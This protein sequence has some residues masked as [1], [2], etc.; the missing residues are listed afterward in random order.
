LNRMLAR[1]FFISFSENM[2]SCV[3]TYRGPF[4]G[5]ISFS[6]NMLSCVKTYRGP[7]RGVIP[8]MVILC[9][10]CQAEKVLLEKDS[11]YN[12]IRV[13]EEGRFISLYC[14]N[15]HQSMVDTVHPDRL[16]FNYTKSM[17]SVFTFKNEIP[18][19]ILLIGEGGGSIPKA[20]QKD[21]PGVRLDIVELDQEVH[22]AAMK[23]FRFK[24]AKNTTINIIDGRMFVKKTKKKYDIVM[25]DAFRGGYIP[26][27]M[28]TSE[29]LGQVKNVLKPGGIVVSNTFDNSRIRDRE[30]ATYYSV[31]KNVY[32]LIASGSGNRII[33]ADNNPRVKKEDL[34]N[35]A[36][37]LDKKY[38]FIGMKLYSIV[39]NEFKVV[40]GGVSAEVL[41]DDHAPAELLA[42]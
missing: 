22:D 35:R 4:R 19:N 11:L 28:L 38:S 7:F 24:P 18:E 42:E 30:T 34:L 3:K 2:L 36:E 33:I 15:G 1:R 21:F 26:F 13:I 6:E 8:L 9:V 16:V 10:F 39:N 32:E 27:H 25:L 29:F 40:S 17:M 5:V 37:K 41:T 12:N 31:F 20:L 14:G 23:Y